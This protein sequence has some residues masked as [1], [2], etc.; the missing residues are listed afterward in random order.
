MSARA[1]VI[2]CVLLVGRCAAAAAD[3][4]WTT[5]GPGW[6]G[7]VIAMTGDVLDI[8]G[9]FPDGDKHLYF[10]RRKVRSIEFNLTRYNGAQYSGLGAQPPKPSTAKPGAPVPGSDDTVVLSFGDKRQ[11]KVTEI[12][13]A[14]IL[15]G[16]DTL[17]RPSVRRIVFAQQ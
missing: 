5:D 8:V 15:C 11:C 17:V 4:V 9:T 1:V 3:T 13:A 14:S 16:S 12:K 2:A 7:S 6:N 10:E